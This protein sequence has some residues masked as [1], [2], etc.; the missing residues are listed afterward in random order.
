MIRYKAKES[1]I[2]FKEVDT[3]KYKPSQTCPICLHEKKK[4]L[5]ERLHDC[6]SCGLLIGRDEASAIYLRRIN[7]ELKGA[8]RPIVEDYLRKTLSERFK[9]SRPLKR[10][11]ISITS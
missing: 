11:T 6:Q 8:E 3:R 7:E 10:E 2:E 5:S 9:A 1:C 4:L